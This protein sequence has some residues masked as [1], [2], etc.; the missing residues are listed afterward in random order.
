[1]TKA[2]HE[3]IYIGNEMGFV[4]CVHMYDTHFM[5]VEGKTIDGKKF[6]ITI[7]IQE[8]EKDA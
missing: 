4:E 3:L 6:S 7:N 8:E 2:L 5:S 1:M